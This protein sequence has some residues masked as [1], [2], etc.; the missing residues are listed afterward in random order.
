[1]EDEE[2]NTS[3]QDLPY[4]VFRA[5]LAQARG[6]PIPGSNRFAAVCRTWRDDSPPEDNEL[7]L[8]LDQ[9]AVKGDQLQRSTQWLAQHGEGVAALELP[10]TTWSFVRATLGFPGLS[11]SL[12]RLDIR[13]TN[14]LVGLL[15]A[16]VQLPRLQH[17]TACLSSYQAWQVDPG[18]LLLEEGQQAT[19]TLHPLQQACPALVQL[20]LDIDGSGGFAAQVPVSNMDGLLQRLLP[21]T[22]QQL[23]LDFTPDD[24]NA[25]IT[26]HLALGHLTALQRLKLG[27]FR[28]SYL[29]QLTLLV[30]DCGNQI[31]NGVA[32]PAL[33]S[34]MAVVVPL[35]QGSHPAS[36]RQ[37]VVHFTGAPVCDVVP[38]PLRGVSVGVRPL[39]AAA[40]GFFP[41]PRA[42]R[43]M[44]PCPHLPG[45]WELLPG[46]P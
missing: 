8:Y 42:P 21:P 5:I 46:Q 45:V 16:Q 1:M 36:L 6:R 20:R 25:L 22:L 4:A 34:C 38:S 41:M 13:G 27:C 18:V 30:V 7:Q 32:L 11:S 40:D 26:P 37:L 9:A 19:G 44:Q 12:Q 24:D 14:T 33:S 39:P 29:T 31:H 3:M 35:L 28:L 17:L 43:A 23:R 10:T 15:A 2:G